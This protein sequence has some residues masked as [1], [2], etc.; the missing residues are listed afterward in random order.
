MGCEVKGC[1][2]GGGAKGEG[3]YVVG[4][5]VLGFFWGVW[6]LVGVVGLGFGWARVLWGG[7]GWGGVGGK[8]EG[9]QTF[10]CWTSRRQGG[11]STFL[12][13]K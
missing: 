1:G 2:W 10:T 7:W 5:V 6:W 9:G 4:L 11:K 13:S 8:R 12:L 3:R